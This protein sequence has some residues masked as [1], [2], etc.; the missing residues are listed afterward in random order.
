M[1][2]TNQGLWLLTTLALHSSCPGIPRPNS[3]WVPSVLQWEF[4]T[5]SGYTQPG[6]P[7]S[8]CF[9]ALLDRY[10]L[11]PPLFDNRD[12]KN[13]QTP[14]NFEGPH[15]LGARKAFQIEQLGLEEPRIPGWYSKWQSYMSGSKYCISFES[16][17][18]PPLPKS[19]PLASQG[20]TKPGDFRCFG[21]HWAGAHGR[22]AG[23]SW[24]WIQP[25]CLIPERALRWK[26]TGIASYQ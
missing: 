10:S 25:C 14:N 16:S 19:H 6:L 5:Q 1:H 15:F 24:T 21:S 22:G 20:F 8:Q 17:A 2:I 7:C 12:G 18:L 3:V 4:P 26:H 23:C 9:H 11:T 13:F